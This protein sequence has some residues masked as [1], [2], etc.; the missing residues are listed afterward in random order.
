M[1]NRKRKSSK[2]LDFLPNRTNRYAIR[3]FTVGTASI[4]VGTLLYFGVQNVNNEAQAAENAT[5]SQKETADGQSEN[6]ESKNSNHTETSDSVEKNTTRST[7]E[8]ISQEDSEKQ[9][10]LALKEKQVQAKKKLNNM[11]NLNDSQKLEFIDD[12]EQVNS[13]SEIERILINAQSTEEKAEQASEEKANQEAEEKAE[14]ASKDK[15]NQEADEKAEQEAK[16]QV[17]K[18]ESEQSSEEER[19]QDSDDKTKE[20]SDNKTEKQN[21]ELAQEQEASKEEINENKSDEDKSNES[22]KEDNNSNEVNEETT[23]KN[24][25]TINTTENKE[26]KNK[27]DREEKKTVEQNEETLTKQTSNEEKSTNSDA[28][29][30]ESVEKHVDN[31]GDIDEET[32]KLVDELANVDTNEE[33][34]PG[35]H[36]EDTLDK[37]D[38]GQKEM[39]INAMLNSNLDSEQVEEAK[40]NLDI[41]YSKDSSKEILDAVTAEAL[42]QAQEQSDLYQP[43]ATK[44]AE[45]TARQRTS[46]RSASTTSSRAAIQTLAAVTPPKNNTDYKDLVSVSTVNN[47]NN[48]STRD[49]TL[50]VDQVNVTYL[51]NGQ[52]RLRFPVSVPSGI[53]LGFNAKTRLDIG[54]SDS[55]KSN[56][57]SVKNLGEDMA[58]DNATGTYYIEKEKALSLSAEGNELDVEIL[59]A[60]QN[61][62]PTDKVEIRYNRKVNFG[63]TAIDKSAVITFDKLSAFINKQKAANDK[64]Q[65]FDTASDAEKQ[66]MLATINNANTDASLVSATDSVLNTA[67]EIGKNNID[68]QTNLSNNDKTGFKSSIQNAKTLEEIDTI[69][70]QASSLSKAKEA[71]NKQVDGLTDLTSQEKKGYKNQINDATSVNQIQPIVDNA[72]KQD[73]ANALSK[74]KEAANKQIDGLTDLTSQEKTGYKNQINDATSVNQIQPIVDNAKKQDQA[75]ALSKAKEA[76]NKQIDGL[77]NLTSQEKTGYKNQ[78]NGTTS[79]NQI[80][81]IVD[82]AKKQDQANALANAKA[83]ANKTVDGLTNLTSQEKDRYKN[84][85]ND[86]TNINQ[87][88]PIVDNAKKQDQSIAADKKAA[89]LEGLKAAQA[90][91]NAVDEENYKPN[92]YEPLNDALTTAQEILDNPEAYTQAEIDEATQSIQD[93]LDQLSEKADKAE[94]DEAISEA[95]GLDLDESDAEDKAVADALERAQEVSEDG[96]ATTEEV[97][98]AT[99]ALNAAMEAKETQDAADKKAAALEGLKAAQA[100]GNAIDEDNYKPN[101]YEP[102]NDALTTAQEIIDN[103]EAHTQAE[104]DEATQ[105]IQDAL[106]QL[107]EKADKAE[108]DEAIS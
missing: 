35:K 31:N 1:A 97:T 71:A 9:E 22:S 65:Q 59:L 86:T 91:G 32:K 63:W 81:P 72:K 7:S 104:I 75:N 11:M 69:V 78:I 53:N 95:E 55:M 101:S 37:A 42:R 23:S 82:N 46:L 10:Q 68:G 20:D 49:F 73:Q 29:Q 90:E 93:A 27:N 41:D 51:S 12:I 58:Y 24:D 87:I 107:S 84:Q 74:A 30:Q 96:N 83:E 47:N 4:L 60:E 2:K 108:L 92:S 89:A 38:A 64:V 94:L 15:T 45:N 61:F 76:A 3:K 43:A 26:E 52:I 99:E 44:N 98:T 34:S 14:Q 21:T 18:D 40:E 48:L 57:V 102:L 70:N 8:N 17:N 16:D 39:L 5:A 105:S 28:K 33:S 79:V 62:K 19:K 77:T 6:E 85:I 13:E 36:Y 103:P 56:V 25:K 67:K 50:T 54:L 66:K 80:Q 88:Q 100:E 106:D